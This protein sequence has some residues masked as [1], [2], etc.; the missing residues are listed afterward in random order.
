MKLIPITVVRL[1][2]RSARERLQHFLFSG[3]Y[4]GARVPRGIKPEFVAAFI[5]EKLKPDS[6]PDAYRRALE[7]VRFYERADTLDTFRQAL[8]GKEK[9]PADVVRAAYALTALGDLGNEADAKQAAAYFEKYI[10]PRPG[11]TPETYRELLATVVALAPFAA[12][13]T[14]VQQ[15]DRQIQELSAGRSSSEPALFAYDKMAAVRRNDVPRAT[16]NVSLKN[17]LVA[18]RADVR[19]PEF[20]RIYLDISKRGGEMLAT[21]SGRMLRKDAI[22]GNHDP[23][24]AELQSAMDEI[25]ETELGKEGADTLVVRAG[26]AVIYLQ[27][28]LTAA[29]AARYRKAGAGGL[30]FLWDDLP[31][32]HLRAAQEG[33]EP[34]EVV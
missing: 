9:D 20:A 24:Y 30:N 6:P 3:M 2:E 14:L 23:V 11:L 15:I 29:R 1:D 27:G 7:V 25:S 13:G 16:L 8:T 12:P 4:G 26:Q 32:T 5:N 33:E 31:Q 10:V 28:G 18:A 19:R 17:T 21:W 22:D 34:E